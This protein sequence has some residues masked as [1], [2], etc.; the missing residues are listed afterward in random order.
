MVPQLNIHRVPR[1]LE[2]YRPAI[3]VV[4][5]VPIPIPKLIFTD[6]TQTLAPLKH[7][8]LLRSPTQTH[9]V[10]S[11]ALS[12]TLQISP[13]LARLVLD[14]LS[15]TLCSDCDE[16]ESVRGANVDDLILFL[17]FQSYKRLLPRTHKDSAAV[18]DVWPSTSAFDGYLSALSQLLSCRFSASLKLVAMVEGTRSHDVK[19]IEETLK[20][21][22]QLQ[23]TTEIQAAALEKQ[24]EAIERQSEVMTEVKNLISALTLKYDQL[25]TQL[26]RSNSRR[27][28]PSESDDE[29]HQLSYLQKH[30]AN[31]ISLLADSVEGKSE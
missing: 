14:T 30:L 20:A 15:A 7:K 25:A 17:Y 3:S 16:I 18:A 22:G 1:Y 27:F 11:T 31:I 24:S 5:S 6:G 26:V 28:M 29:A 12:G 19:R 23:T 13:D 8:L 21:V 10:D 9:Q 4:N 2:L